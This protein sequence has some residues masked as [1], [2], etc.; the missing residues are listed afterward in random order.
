MA[1]QSQR[2]DGIPIIL[3]ITWTAGEAERN[4]PLCRGH[5]GYIFEGYLASAYGRGR[6][7]DQCSMCISGLSRLQPPG[8]P[9][10]L[11]PDPT[12]G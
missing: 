1:L 9:S 7:S 10:P 3:W 5:Q 8:L 6:R 2:T 4:E 12:R 11:P